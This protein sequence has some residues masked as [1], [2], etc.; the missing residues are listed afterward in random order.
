MAQARPIRRLSV[1]DIPFWEHAKKHEFRLQQC[2]NCGKWRW[3]P[4]AS[5]DSCLS[6]DYSWN[7]LSGE[8]KVKSWIT[9]HRPYFP[10]CPPP[11][12]VVTVELKEGPFFVSNPVGFPVEELKLDLPVK[13]TWLEAEDS[14]GEFSLP[15]FT[16][17]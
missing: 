1:F 14:S 4:A 8:G 12:H 2:S 9:F 10:E 16:K 3:P 15:V 7:M 13:V 17:V 6:E 5:C 11:H